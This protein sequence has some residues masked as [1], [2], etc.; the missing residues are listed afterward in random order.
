LTVSA[1]AAE[2][3]AQDS[4]TDAATVAHRNILIAASPL[5]RFFVSD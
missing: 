5:F 4:S 2:D 3:S 1:D